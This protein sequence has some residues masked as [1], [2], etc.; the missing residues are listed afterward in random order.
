LSDLEAQ[1]RLDRGRI[2]AD[3]SAP[4]VPAWLVRSASPPVS[5]KPPVAS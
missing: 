3:R 5:A 1:P 2:S 4:I